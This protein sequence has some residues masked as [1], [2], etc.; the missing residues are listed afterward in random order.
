MSH[1]VKV[2]KL[3]IKDIKAIQKA[4]ERVGG[5]V[6][7][8][9]ERRRYQLFSSTHEG[10]GVQLPGWNYPIVVD[11]DTGE[12]FYDNYN[13][14]WGNPQQ[15]DA[16]AQAYTVEKA[17]VEAMLHGMVVEEVQHENGEIEL[18]MTQYEG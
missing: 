3:E 15:L 6:L 4:A 5:K 14:Q 8:A 2:K 7:N 17:K 18:R 16:F 12:V 10:V 9:G 13:G 1:T 11:T